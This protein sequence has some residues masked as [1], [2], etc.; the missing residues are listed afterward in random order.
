M[1]TT[2]LQ[3]NRES[4]LASLLSE[5][6]FR[7]SEPRSLEEAGLPNSLVEALVC[8]HLKNPDLLGSGV[9]RYTYY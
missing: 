5:E 4:L 6:A 3:E 2:T 1:A 7:P 8:K 9:V